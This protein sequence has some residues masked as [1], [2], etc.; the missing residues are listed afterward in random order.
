MEFTLF[1][2]DW[3]LKINK[4][5]YL[6]RQKEKYTYEEI[7]FAPRTSDGYAEIRNYPKMSRRS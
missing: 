5:S 4:K 1:P 7:S 2:K 3:I 6:H